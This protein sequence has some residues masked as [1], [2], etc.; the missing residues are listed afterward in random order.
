[1]CPPQQFMSDGDF[2]RSAEGRYPTN[3][4]GNVHTHLSPRSLPLPPWVGLWRAE[5]RVPRAMMRWC[6]ATTSDGPCDR[7]LSYSDQGRVWG[8]FW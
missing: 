3:S 6:M 2:R 4:I 8:Q 5:A 7:P 1:M